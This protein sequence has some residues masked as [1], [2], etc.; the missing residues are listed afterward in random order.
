MKQINSDKTMKVSPFTIDEVEAHSNA[1][2]VLESNAKAPKEAIDTISVWGGFFSILAFLVFLIGGVLTLN[3]TIT[4]TIY[5]MMLGSL[6]VILITISIV[7]AVKESEYL[8]FKNALKES[9]KKPEHRSISTKIDHAEVVEAADAINNKQG[10]VDDFNLLAQCYTVGEWVSRNADYVVIMYA[11]AADLDDMDA[12]MKVGEIFEDG[13][14]VQRNEQ[15]AYEWYQRAQELGSLAATRKIVSME[16]ATV[17]ADI[18]Q[19]IALE[20]ESIKRK[21]DQ[22]G[23]NSSALGVGI[24]L[25]VAIS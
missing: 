15:V 3:E 4:S 8:P 7:S 25:G 23:G 13:R 11:K 9:K 12:A 16:Y 17:T 19:K 5:F 1:H 14:G 20:S 2:Q 10:S 6:A 21:I 18:K 22:K 24:L